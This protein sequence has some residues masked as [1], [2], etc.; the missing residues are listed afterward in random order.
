M[1][2]VL[3]NSNNMVTHLMR[4]KSLQSTQQVPGNWSF[5][6]PK[7]WMSSHKQEDVTLKLLTVKKSFKVL[8]L[9]TEIH[10]KI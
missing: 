1:Y 7:D 9:S 6:G 2:P 8:Y 4:P 10:S 3:N 5:T